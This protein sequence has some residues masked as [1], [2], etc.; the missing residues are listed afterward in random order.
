MFRFFICVA[1]IFFSLIELAIVGFVEKMTEARRRLLQS[2]RTSTASVRTKSR[3]S[4]MADRP[5]SPLFGLNGIGT[6]TTVELVSKSSSSPNG[7]LPVTVLG[8]KHST[9]N[10]GHD[11]KK[12][13]FSVNGNSNSN[14]WTRKSSFFPEDFTG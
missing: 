12:N 3:A 6:A 5:P 9:A 1:F 8:K 14:G 13:S 11:L 2:K 10:G 7:A 4:Y